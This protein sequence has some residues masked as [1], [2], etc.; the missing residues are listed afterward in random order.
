[1]LRWVEKVLCLDPPFVFLQREK[2]GHL[3]CK[4]SGEKGKNDFVKNACRYLVHS[5]SEANLRFLWVIRDF[6][7]D[8]IFAKPSF[9]RLLASA[10]GLR[11]NYGCGT[12][13]AR[14]GS[15]AA[16]FC[17]YSEKL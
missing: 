5:L 17:V 8:H 9:D 10:S 2:T 11:S 1:M 3:N 6:T 12:S 15:S 13:E 16:A 7:N 14:S 4:F